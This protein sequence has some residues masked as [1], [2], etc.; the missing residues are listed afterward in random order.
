MDRI[1]VAAFSLDA[2]A[3]RLVFVAEDEL[4]LA[5]ESLFRAL[6][7]LIGEA[8]TYHEIPGALADTLLIARSQVQEWWLGETAGLETLSDFARQEH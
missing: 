4:S 3:S 5:K 2:E 8:V 6:P 7:Q 1:F